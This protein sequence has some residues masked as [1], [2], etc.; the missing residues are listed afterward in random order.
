ML[1]VS[2]SVSR[3]GKAVTFSKKGLIPYQSPFTQKVL[4][5]W[6]FVMLDGIS[7]IKL[8]KLPWRLPPET[9]NKRSSVQLPMLAGMVPFNS[10]PDRF[11]DLSVVQLPML[12]GIPPAIEKLLLKSTT[13]SFG[14][15]NIAGGILLKLLPPK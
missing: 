2:T 12:S 5:L 1:V 7:P 11:K 15:L 6:Q 13:S 9:F 10:F 4:S 3:S 8:L 14:Q